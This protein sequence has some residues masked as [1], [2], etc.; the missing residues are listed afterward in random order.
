MLWAHPPDALGWSHVG[1][2]LMRPLNATPLRGLNLNLLVVLDALLST[3]SVTRAAKQL[4]LTQP[5][6][7]RNLAELRAIFADALLVRSGRK[8]LLTPRAQQLGVPLRQALQDLI[9][10]VSPDPTLALHRTERRFK[11]AISDNL[12]KLLVQPLLRRLRVEAPRANCQ[13]FPIPYDSLPES[14]EAGAVDVALGVLW[15]P[16]MGIRREVL[17]RDKFACLLRRGHPILSGGAW[18]LDAYLSLDHLVTT[19]VGNGPGLM[20]KLLEPKGLER[21]VAVRCAWFALAPDILRDS[22]LVSTLPQSFINAILTP[23]LV[24]LPPPLEVPPVEVS[25]SWH[26]RFEGDEIL[27]WL[28]NTLRDLARAIPSVVPGLLA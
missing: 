18:G 17:F 1:T 9:R 25:M 4:G 10:V 11:V 13:F 22:D 6:V 27:C 7:S 16:P 3:R 5:A 15:E 28:R 14:L 26:E 2:Q 12:L 24:V 23:D 8:M 21:R 20:D 19:P